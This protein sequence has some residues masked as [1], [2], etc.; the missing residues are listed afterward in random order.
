MTIK[1]ILLEISEELWRAARA[2]CGAKP[3]NPFIERR[4]QRDAMIRRAAEREGIELPERP[5]DGRG[6]RSE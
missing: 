1:R 3:L 2:A 4:L 6:K 5:E